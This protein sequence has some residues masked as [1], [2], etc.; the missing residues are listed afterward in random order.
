[1]REVVKNV[2]VGFNRLCLRNLSCLHTFALMKK[3]ILI[4]I[5]AIVLAAAVFGA[6]KIF[7]GDPAKKAGEAAEGFLTSFFEMDYDAAAARCSEELGSML[8][9]SMSA[10]SY[11]SENIGERVAEASKG[12]EFKIVSCEKAEEKNTVVV[13]YTILPFGGGAGIDRCMTLVKS[14][15]EWKVTKLE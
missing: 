7:G 15:G 11:P 9:A 8:L 1:M 2:D 14:E 12:T 13:K 10:Q 5:F 4:P 6:V 3:I